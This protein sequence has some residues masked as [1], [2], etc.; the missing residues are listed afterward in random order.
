MEVDNDEIREDSKQ[1]PTFLETIK[2]LN[3]IEG[4]TA[5]LSCKYSPSNDPNLK[6]AWLLN[7]KVTFAFY[8]LIEMKFLNSKKNFYLI[9]QIISV[10]CLQLNFHLL[11]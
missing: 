11:N 10:L 1:P 9:H 5:L 6:I 4:Q 8:L 7:G 2:N 3:L